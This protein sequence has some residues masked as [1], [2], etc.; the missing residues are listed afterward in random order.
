MVAE[1]RLISASAPRRPYTA[2]N[3]ESACESVL[4]AHKV[5]ICGMTTADAAETLSSPTVLR[6]RF[7]DGAFST[8]VSGIVD[9]QTNTVLSRQHLDPCCRHPIS[10]R[11]HSFAEGLASSRSPAPLQIFQPFDADDTDGIPRELLYLLIDVVTSRSPC[12]ELAL[13]SR[14]AA[15][16]ASTDGLGLEPILIAV[17]IDEQLI[18]SDVDS[19]GSARFK[20]AIGDLDPESRPAVTQRAALKQLGA[21]F[22]QPVVE[23]FVTLERNN[24]GLALDQAGDLEH[25]I[26]GSLSWLNLGDEA[27]Q[28]NSAADMRARRFNARSLCGLARRRHGLQRDLEAVG[29]VAVRETSATNAVQ[30]FSIKPSGI[31]PKIVDVA[32]GA[33]LH[34]TQQSGKSVPFS[35][36]GKLQRDFDRTLHGSLAY[37]AHSTLNELKVEN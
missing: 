16:H 6:H 8:G 33:A 14:L 15:A 18:H 10:P 5:C 23:L 30:C 4:R 13:T 36:S 12:S 35:D 22:L 25:V 28:P 31:R 24:N 27:A 7:A 37:Y 3:L 17:G 34:L 32:L 20:I 2:E 1:N 19:D 29:A 21:G 26:E 11:C 9:D